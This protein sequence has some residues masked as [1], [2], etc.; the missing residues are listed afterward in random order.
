MVG[1]LA[2]GQPVS[3]D[4]YDVLAEKDKLCLLRLKQG[5]QY[6]MTLSASLPAEDDT[7][8]GEDV[9]ASFTIP[10]IPPRIGFGD[11]EF[12]LPRSGPGELPISL[13]NVETFPLAIHRIVD[14]SLNRHLALGHIRNGIPNAEYQDL[15]TDFSEV[16]WEGTATR[17][18]EEKERNNSVRTF[19]PVRS[20][21]A[22]RANWVHTLSG[23]WD[24]AGE[25]RSVN[26]PARDISDERLSIDGTFV[27]GTLDANAET[28]DLF[29]PG[30]YALVAPI[31]DPGSNKDYHCADSSDADCVVYAAQWFIVTDIGLT[32]YEGDRDFTVLARSLKSGGPVSGAKIQLVSRGNRLLAEAETDANGVARFSRS[33]TAGEA[34]NALV[35]I[36]AETKDDFNF[37]QYGSERLDL[38]RLNVGGSSQETQSSAFL[39]TDRGIYQPGETIETLALLRDRSGAS[40][41]AK[42]SELR[43][44]VSDYVVKTLPIAASEWKDGGNLLSLQLPKTV[45]PGTAVLKLVSAADDVLAETRMQI[46]KIRPDRARIEFG[47]DT[48][49]GLKVHIAANGTA[50]VTGRVHAQYLYGLEGTGQGAAANLKAEVVIRV[51]PV[52]TPVE[53][54]YA[55]FAFGNFDDESLP[56]V[57]RNFVEYTDGE[58]MLSLRLSGVRLPAATKPLAAAVEVTLFDASGPLASG[59]AVIA[60]PAREIALGVSALPRLALADAGGYVVGLDVAAIGAD[61]SALLDRDIDIRLEREHESYAWE[62]VDGV[63]QHIQMRQREEVSSRT[64]RLA[65][66]GPASGATSSCAGFV[67][68]ADAATGIDDGRYVVTVSDK[69]SGAVASIRFGTGVAQTSIE[70]L[71]PNIFV[72]SSD[73]KRYAPGEKIS[74]T[75]EAPFRTGQ[76]LV[77]V[78]GRDILNWFPGEVHDGKGTITFNADPAWA[79]KGLHALAT[80]FKADTGDSRQLGPARAIGAT[81][82]EVSQES[83]AFAVSIRRQTSSLDD[84]LRPGEPLAFDVCIDGAA[85]ECGGASQAA[86]YAVAFVVDEGLLSLTGHEAEADRI[87]KEFLGIEKLGLRA[88][89]NYGRL[90]LREGGDRPGRLALSNYTSARIVAAARGPVA[91][92]NGRATF[93]FDDPGL[94]SGSLKIHVVAWS[95]DHIAT[96]R[97]TIAVRH[98]LVSNLGVPEFFLAGDKPILPLHIE[99]V[100]FIDHK[101]NY[102]LAFHV[103]GGIGISLTQKDGSPVATDGNG[104]FLLPVSADQPQD[105]QVALD[106]PTAAEGA[107]QLSLGLSAVGG[108]VD[109]PPEERRRS[110]M[111][112]VHPSAVASQEYLSFP[113]SDRPAD[114]AAL[115]KGVVDNRYDPE[116][117]KIVARF[118]GGGDI[119]RVASLE[120]A[121]GDAAAILDEMVWL[122][123]VDLQDPT[124]ARDTRLKTQVQANIDGIQALQLADGA[125]V[126]YR[127]QGDFIPAEVGFDKGTVSYSVRHGLLRNVS[128]L[129]FLIRARAAGYAVSPD[130]I[131]N[132]IAFVKARVNDAITA[133]NSEVDIGL[134]CT[135]DTRY[136]MLVLVQQDRLTAPDVDSLR[137]CG[138]ATAA[139][140]GAE[141]GESAPEV[142][143]ASTDDTVFSELVNLAVFSEFGEDVDAEEALAAHYDDP[144][145]YLGDL[146]A[147]RKA[148][149]LSMLASAR[150][151]PA[152][153][154]NVAGSFFEE[155]KPLDLRTRA[156]LARSVAD[157]GIGDVEKLTVANLQAS[158][159]DMVALAQRPDGVVES[160]ELE[161]AEIE[162]EALTVSKI[163]GPDARGFLRIGGKLLDTEEMALPETSL[164]RRF[165][166]ADNGREVDPR[167]QKLQVGDRLIVVLEATSESLASFADQDLS[168]IG[169]SY[170]PLVVDAQLPSGLTL[171]SEDVSG[172]KPKGDFARLTMVG[173]V[174]SVESHAQE[175]NA[176]IVPRS[177]QGVTA[178]EQGEGEQP[179]DQSDAQADDQSDDQS[180]IGE[181]GIEFRQAFV[182][183]VTAAGS[184]LFPAIAVDPLDFPGDTLLSQQMRLE[185]AVD[186]GAPR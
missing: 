6:E 43:L 52:A 182:V 176:I 186:G 11:G 170:G 65:D 130:A 154:A 7:V 59:R 24:R 161:Y 115:L 113:L 114:L 97:Q 15:L 37:L 12:I 94:Q 88:M 13:T 178:H 136:A 57:S 83:S 64:V 151:D 19:V 75:V 185:V 72:L 125:F 143:E 29:V 120:T 71:E 23:S 36:M 14:R 91:F 54:C 61:G 159:P 2:A 95:P 117:V 92:E 56:T 177:S 4:G 171:I 133:A 77:A 109:L 155:R 46:G 104:A 90:L 35:A 82:F 79:G 106:I 10:D 25:I 73:K 1:L 110:W 121:P 169:S 21:L 127:T 51:A 167:Q 150:V 139:G 140:D 34:S 157:L 67:H 48:A 80:V 147:Y 156:W 18:M 38:S 42:G 85:G 162:R 99:N 145:Q 173:N 55:D 142:V 62:N 153:V 180:D 68:V 103:E 174:R 47:K 70:D 129:D 146:D 49:D 16:L 69:T 5:I 60:V 126:P 131:R 137:K 87:E 9:N 184:F 50:E 172:I 44:E 102:A 132:S 100:S 123:M 112:D 107:F 141:E 63:W 168:D 138:A 134:L 96:A 53:G 163:G 22:D 183:T 45:R 8:L 124:L 119:L 118:A 20:I 84:F 164:R 17:S 128:A 175:W 89:D 98:F 181:P 81:R 149:A 105:L 160:V 166:R 179:D 31:P 30:V 116:T 32:F 3:P 86:G 111:L 26:Q 41:A 33:L 158:D 76:V 108:P 148:I 101:G 135:F 58:G 165:F 39:Y 122:G 78:A 93:S 28:S 27:A 152:V 144:Q 74:L 40:E 66:L